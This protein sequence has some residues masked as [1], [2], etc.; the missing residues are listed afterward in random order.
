MSEQSIGRRE[1]LAGA[2]GAGLLILKP[3]LVRGTQANSAVRVGLLGC[4]GRGTDVATGMVKNAG[5]R[6]TALADLFPDQLD[7][8]QD[9]FGAMSPVAKSQVFSGPDAAA[10]IAASKEV[11]AIYIATPPYFHVEHLATVAPSGKH[12]Y[13]EKPV[14]VDVPGAK[15][16]LE[17]GRQIGNRSTLAVGFQIRKAPPF[18]ELVKRIHAGALGDIVCGDAHYWAGFIWRPDWPGSS[19]QALRLRNWIYDQALSGDIIVE[20]NIHVIDVVNWALKGHPVKAVGTGGRQGRAPNVSTYSHFDVMFTYPNDVHISFSSTQFSEKGYFDAS[21]RL[22]GTNGS[23]QSPYSGPLGIAGPEPW[24]WGASQQPASGQFSA[25]GSFGDNLA[26]A[27]P[28]KQKA[29]VGSIASGQFLNEAE[30]GVESALSAMLGRTAAY[31]GR[32]VT[33]DE[34]LASNETLDPRLDIRKL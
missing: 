10:K 11:D 4:G 29:F 28:E 16:V 32:P 17:I 34:L 3:E 20:Q 1:F 18:V 27:D 12:I 24:T 5:A 23:S 9:H 15:R 25:T 31:N 21:E 8:A 33:W 6:I 26:Q 2:A 14:A 19:P 30:Q 13:L 7:K 22:F